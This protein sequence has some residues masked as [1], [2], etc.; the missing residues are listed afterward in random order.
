MLYH[1]NTGLYI[2]NAFY[3]ASD[4]R[5]YYFM[6]Y[7]L[8][9]LL[10]TGL[11]FSFRFL[12]FYVRRR[13]GEEQDRIM[14]IGG[15]SAGQA[16]IK[17]LTGSAAIRP[18]YA[19]SLMT[20]LTNGS[21]MLEGIPIVETRNDILE[22]VEKYRINRIN[23]CVPA[24]TGKNR[25]DILNICK[26][27]SCRLQTVPSVAQLVNGEVKVTRLRDVEITDLLGRAR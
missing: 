14:V 6:G 27:T 12:R 16:V 4:A 25:K 23:L 13:E 7:V 8:S 24:T 15:G 10:T 22:A 3:E 18:E 11:R 9:F 2:W 21:R 20:T 19:V 1:F 17:E 5:S 26:E